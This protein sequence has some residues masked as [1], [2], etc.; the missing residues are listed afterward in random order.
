[1]VV[2]TAYLKFIVLGM[3][4]LEANSTL[5]KA[6]SSSVQTAQVQSTRELQASLEAA[7]RQ[8]AQGNGLDTAYELVGI[9]DAAQTGKLPD[10]SQDAVR[11]LNGV[12]QRAAQ[13]ALLSNLEDAQDILD[14][15]IDLLFFARTSNVSSAD[16]S[17]QSSLRTVFPKMTGDLRLALV[18]PIANPGQ[19]IIT[20]TNL[21]ML[22]ELEAAASLVML[23]DIAASIRQSYDFE[24]VRL[25]NL[26]QTLTDEAQRT[27][28]LADLSEA[29]KIRAE[30][31]NDALKNNVTNVAAE[32]AKPGQSP[33]KDEV[34]TEADSDMSD[35]SL[36]CVEIGMIA[37]PSMTSNWDGLQD[38]LSKLEDECAL[39]GR[40]PTESRCEAKD[41]S[42]VYREATNDKM[43]RLSFVY[44]GTPEERTML[45][46]CKGDCLSPTQLASTPVLFKNTAMR[47]ILTCSPA[48]G[49]ARAQD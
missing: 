27:K 22:A 14:Q 44:Q 15:F 42:F 25:E 40:V 11:T 2:V 1:M 12:L 28:T 35:V 5:A 33:P 9:I 13:T 10:V 49:S 18:K 32:M 34:S 17:L 21:S 38:V 3:L 47:R 8:A 20:L 45:E 26:A 46:N 7:K 4:L 37:P 29:K 23:D 39:S 6:Q 48:P 43:E 30:Q 24:A 16:A 41:V 36:A 31:V 19:W